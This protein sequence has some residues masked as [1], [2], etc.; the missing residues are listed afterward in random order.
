[1]HEKIEKISFKTGKNIVTKVF[2]PCSVVPTFFSQPLAAWLLGVHRRHATCTA[3]LRM[4]VAPSLVSHLRILVGAK[5]TIRLFSKL[6][7]GFNVVFLIP[8]FFVA[9]MI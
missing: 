1:M 9:E 8:E 6:L 7:Q 2:L 4:F 3:R 5:V